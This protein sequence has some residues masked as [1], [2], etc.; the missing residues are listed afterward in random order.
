MHLIHFCLQRQRITDNSIYLLELQSVFHLHNQLAS[1]ENIISK[2]TGRISLVAYHQ[3]PVLLIVTNQI[4][5]Q[6]VTWDVTNRDMLLLAN[7]Q[8]LLEKKN[9]CA[10][11]YYICRV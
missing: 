2:L 3:R 8:Y 7:I 11:Y 9:H 6:L 10:P 5:L 4:Q 1:L